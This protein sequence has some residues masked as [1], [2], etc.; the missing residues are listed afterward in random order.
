[1][2][3]ESADLHGDGAPAAPEAVPPDDGSDREGIWRRIATSLL[4]ALLVAAGLSLALSVSPLLRA[5]TGIGASGPTASIGAL[6]DHFSR[7]VPLGTSWGE[8]T[9]GRWQSRFSNVSAYLVNGSEAQIVAS[10]ETTYGQ[11]LPVERVDVDLRAQVAWTTLPQGRSASVSLLARFQD[12]RNTYRGALIQRQDGSL[13]AQLSKIVDDQTGVLCGNAFLSARYLPGS[14]WWL[15]L[16]LRGPNLW[17]KAW[18]ADSP[19]PAAWSR[20]CTDW[21]LG[22]AGAVGVRAQTSKRASRFSIDDF[23]LAF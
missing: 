15:R 8:G 20:R 6:S 23:T 7:V 19:E 16:R 18:P 13:V 4:L 21:S 10:P 17:L 9:L 12:E 14:A 2:R 22:E 11:T 1:M 3:E 5:L